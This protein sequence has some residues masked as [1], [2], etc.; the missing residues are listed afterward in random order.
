MRPN[1]SRA[2]LILLLASGLCLAQVPPKALPVVDPALKADPGNDWFELARNL[3]DSA[4]AS[5]DLDSRADLCSRA[6]AQFTDY[7]AEYPNHPNA[8]AAWWYLGQCQYMSG[9]IED[10]QRCFNTLINRYVKGKWVAAAAYTL[11][12][13]HYNKREYQFAAPLFEKAAAN[14]IR[15]EDC[16]R[17]GYYAG[18]CY[19]LLGRD[20]EAAASFNLV[21][22]DKESGNPFSGSAKVGLATIHLKNGKTAEA[23]SLFREVADTEGA[24][25]TRGEAALQAALA[26]SKLGKPEIADKYL[27]FLLDT[28]GMETFRPDAG[29]A[30]LANEFAC[31]EYKK[32][33]E[34]FRSGSPFQDQEKEAQRLTF[35]A[36]AFLNLNQPQEALPLFRSIERSVPPENSLAFE[37]SYYRLLCFYRIEGKH[38]PE[39]V[40]AFLQI[41]GT[42]HKTDPKI[43]TALLMK[44]ESLFSDKHIAEAAKVYSE[45]DASLLSPK[46][47]PGYLYQRGWCLAEAGDPQG[48][49]RSLDKF[50]GDYPDDKRV[51]LA[52]AKRAKAL[53][54]NGEAVRA[55]D[56]FE[57]LIRLKSDPELTSFAWL[58]AARLKKTANDL[59]GMIAH[60]QGLLDNSPKLNDAQRAEADY[61]IGWALVKQNQ[62]KEAVPFL[63]QARKLKPETY[64]KHAGLLLVLGYFAAQDLDKLS[65]EITIAIDGKYQSDIPEQALHWAGLQAYNAARYVEAAR[66]LGM[67][68]NGEEPRATPKE[69]WRYLGKSLL[70]TGKPTESLAAAGQVLTVEDN[71]SWKADALLDK[72][73]SLFALKRDT[74]AAKAADEALELHP[75]GPI[76][77]GLRILKADI[78]MR[79]NDPSTAAA[80]LAVVPEFI[81]DPKLTPLA[82]FK[83]AQ[84]LEKKGDAAGAEKSRDT[85]KIR[86]PAWKPTAP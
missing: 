22:R 47:R 82:L 71:P 27:N 6:A 57:K 86:F 35:A 14:S 45:I 79:A 48:A 4:Q 3:Y 42:S 63:E 10:A 46:N 32:V 8:E 83:L 77:A 61:W 28:P 25:G 37:A 23:L 18:T 51:P 21:L 78:A 39:Q 11:A 50:I 33:T 64:Q 84:A 41:Y 7:L 34:I 1:V 40:D 62:G 15:S 26:A 65:A 67:I 73:R 76:N 59:P 69:V 54:A 58:E 9:H 24:P 30:L 19:R 74:E 53:A 43:H 52:I 75:Q 5:K 29:L 81:D 66:F 38:V 49:I 17:A 31:K 2:S 44:A 13:D 36:Q 55:A 56:D 20:R 72:G 16:Q 68:A 12:A 70:E 80:Q 85:L 60:Y